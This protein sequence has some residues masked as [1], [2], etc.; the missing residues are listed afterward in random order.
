MN[1][2]FPSINTDIIH[3]LEKT[4]TRIENLETK[5]DTIIQN[6]DNFQRKINIIHDLFNK[7]KND[8]DTIYTIL[9]KQLNKINIE[10]LNEQKID[11]LK[12]KLS[13]LEKKLSR[14]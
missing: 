8:K 4:N 9:N 6:Q 2:H 3:E 5:I 11:Q 12:H 7:Y 10:I 13:N 14:V 1:I